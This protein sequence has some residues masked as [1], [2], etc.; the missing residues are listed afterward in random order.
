VLARA[1]GIGGSAPRAWAVRPSGRIRLAPRALPV[2]G[3]AVRAAPTV[4]AGSGAGAGATTRRAATR[5]RAPFVTAGTGGVTLITPPAGLATSSEVGSAAGGAEGCGNGLRAADHRQS[6][7]PGNPGP[8]R[9]PQRRA[10]PGRRA[11]RRR[12]TGRCPPSPWTVLDEHASQTAEKGLELRDRPEPPR[13]RAS[14]RKDIVAID[15]RPRDRS[16]Q[17]PEHR[18]LELP[19]VD[20]PHDPLLGQHPI[21]AAHLELMPASGALDCRPALRDERIV[22]LVLSA[23]ALAGDVHRFA[24]RPSRC[25]LSAGVRCASGPSIK[26]EKPPES[27]RT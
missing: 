9:G 27:T 7:S 17:L 21:G 22:K 16:L 19:P 5:A 4:P 12:A 23:A 1:G 24:V 18:E 6:R 11:L 15:L 26:E 10:A 13:P 25:G 14:S 8:L 2:A 20:G 3:A